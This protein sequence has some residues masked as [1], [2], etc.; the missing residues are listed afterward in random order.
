MEKDYYNSDMSYLAL[1]RFSK[2]TEMIHSLIKEHFDNSEL[3]LDE[4][5]QMKGQPVWNTYLKEWIIVKDVDESFMRT[6]VTI[7]TKD[8]EFEITFDCKKNNMFL[9]KES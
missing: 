5:K 1:K 7:I 3:T 6:F 4:L 9:Q 2:N 8:G